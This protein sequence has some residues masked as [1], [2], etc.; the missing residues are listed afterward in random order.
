M[1]PN[2]YLRWQILRGFAGRTRLS[3]ADAARIFW[4]GKFT[5]REGRDAF[6][7]HLAALSPDDTAGAA[8]ALARLPVP[9]QLIWGTADPFQSWKVA[10]ARLQAL[11]PAADV[12]RLEGCGHFTPL[13]CPDR[14]LSALLGP[15]GR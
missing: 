14:L 12:A 9:C 15:S 13:D 7:R 2:P 6:E 1:I 11:L 4:D 8:P 10:G 5:E 3:D